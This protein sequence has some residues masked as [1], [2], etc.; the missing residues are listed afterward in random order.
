MRIN[1]ELQIRINKELQ[2][3]ED[4]S[5]DDIEEMQHWAEDVLFN[6]KLAYPTP[7]W[8]ELWYKELGYDGRM[9]LLVQ[10]TAIPQRVLMSIVRQQQS[11]DINRGIWTIC[12]KQINV[13]LTR[14]TDQINFTFHGPTPY[15]ELK[16]AHPEENYDPQLV[17][18]TRRGYAIE[19]LKAIGLDESKFTVIDAIR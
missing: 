14:G 1:K 15:P 9:R 5:T 12:L 11:P 17:V 19:W 8:L 3:W 18:R 13:L 2:I 10:S 4:L 7:A 16:A 6:G